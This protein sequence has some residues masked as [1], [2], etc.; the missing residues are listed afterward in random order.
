MKV[1]FTKWAFGI[2]LGYIQNKKM[3][4][5][6]EIKEK[7]IRRSTMRRYIYLF[8]ALT[9][10]VVGCS[11]ESNMLSPVN[12]VNTLYNTQEPNWITLPLS[13]TDANGSS[14]MAK[15]M[16]GANKWIDAESCDQIGSEVILFA[17]EYIEGHKGG[18]IKIDEKIPGGPFGEID[19]KA[20]LKFPKDA[21]IGN[22]N[23]TMVIETS[24]GTATFSPHATFEKCAVYN[25]E[26]KGLDLSGINPSDI[27][28][29]YKTEKGKYEFIDKSKIEVD[30]KDGKLK[31]RD[32]KLP[33]FSRY[34]FVRKDG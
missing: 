32:A 13:N 1:T 2:C 22:K 34:G 12:N 6:M 17:A 10:F 16:T 29:V 4:F 27:D 11:E 3:N 31:V 9:L 8:T 28:F 19:V 30:L 33:H 23:I 14:L 24:F 15:P 25:A 5:E 26:I 7:N 18:S 21:F 20:E